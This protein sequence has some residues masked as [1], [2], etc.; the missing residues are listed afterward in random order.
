MFDLVVDCFYIFVIVIVLILCDVILLWLVIVFIVC[1][2]CMV[3][4]MLVLCICGFI[5]LLVYFV[6]K[7]VIFC[8]LYF[9]LLVLFGCF[10]IGGWMVC[11][12][13]GWVFVVWGIGFYWW[14][15]FFYL[16]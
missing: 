15:F 11:R 4:F 7:V 10:G 1:D 12:V 14:V 6:G 9:F 8:L 3:C 16:V 13:L 2:V 5:F